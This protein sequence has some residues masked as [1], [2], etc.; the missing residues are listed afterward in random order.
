MFVNMQFVHM[1]VWVHT[2]SRGSKKGYLCLSVALYV[3]PLKHS[4]LLN[5]KFANLARLP[6]H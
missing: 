5:E 3:I 2:F 6:D 4:L 1:N